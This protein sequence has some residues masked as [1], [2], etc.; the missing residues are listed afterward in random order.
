MNLSEPYTGEQFVI[1]MC[2]AVLRGS[3]FCMAYTGL[4]LRDTGPRTRDTGPR[5]RDT[6]PRARDTGPRARDTGP[7][8]RSCISHTACN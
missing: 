2:K 7:S 6:G 3:R 4:N 8:V 1:D 5:A